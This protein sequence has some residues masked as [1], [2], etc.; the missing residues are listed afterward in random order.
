M[1]DCFNYICNFCPNTSF[2]HFHILLKVFNIEFKKH[3]CSTECYLLR[4]LKLL[5]DNY[6]TMKYIQSSINFLTVIVKII[7]MEKKIFHYETSSTWP[8]SVKFV[9]NL[10]M[11]MLLIKY[12][13]SR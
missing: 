3:L 5:L 12:S 7:I 13:S 6:T 1:D 11:H 9:C 4:V 8:G 2:V 10:S